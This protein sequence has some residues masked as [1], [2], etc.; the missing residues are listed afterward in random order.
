MM[1]TYEWLNTLRSPVESKTLMTSEWM[2]RCVG[3]WVSHRRYL[4]GKDR[5]VDNLV[6]EF[7][8]DVT[9]DGWVVLWQSDRN[10]G[11]M[12]LTV[13]G[14]WLHRSCG[15]YTKEPT[16]SRIERVDIDTLVFYSEYSGMKFREEIRFLMM[17]QYRLRQTVGYKDGELIICG[18]YFEE[19]V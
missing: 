9:D 13:E 15:Y 11:R 7:S 4:Y 19:R 12:E 16:S 5:K 3:R 2:D 14:D 17:D 8:T 10:E 6:T 1:T 18:Q